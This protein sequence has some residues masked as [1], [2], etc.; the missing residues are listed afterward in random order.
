MSNVYKIIW[1]VFLLST[2][3]FAQLKARVNPA[4]T[5]G[6]SVSLGGCNSTTPGVQYNFYRG[7]TAKGESTTPLNATPLSTCSYVDTT[8]VV[9]GTY[10]YVAKAY[11]SVGGLSAGSNEVSAAIPATTGANTPTGL[12]VAAPATL[13]WT[14]PATQSGYNLLA[15]EIYRGT[16][17]TTIGTTPVAIVLGSQI[18]YADTSCTAPC[19]YYVVAYDLLNDM[20]FTP[21]GPS[22]IASTASTTTP[23]AHV[24][25]ACSSMTVEMSATGAWPA[26]CT[27]SKTGDAISAFVYCHPSA[28]TI[29]GITL[30]APGY[31]VNGTGPGSIYQADAPGNT[32]SNQVG[33]TFGIIALNTS[34]VTFTASFA[35]ASN[36]SDY[37]VSL[38][39]EYTN[40]SQVGGKT[41]FNASGS[42]AGASGT[43]NQAGAA[44]TPPLA[45][46]AVSV[47]C[48]S[49]GGATAATSPWILGE[50]DAAT[51]WD[52][53][54]YQ[55]VPTAGK[56]VTPAFTDSTG[57]YVV[58]SVA[59]APAN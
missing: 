36:C 14:A 25:G 59:I 22:N 48:I 28:G 4:A 32:G 39:E 26:S 33:A 17:P 23:V 55:I 16:S 43:C 10:F 5:G 42:A 20:S 47:A 2:V 29:T 58:Q 13:Q 30:T 54:E 57:A 56:T 44:V 8:V 46:E 9:G 53:D 49:T 34:P 6:P 21:S 18:T 38:S 27:P 11:L 19:S 45:N 41:T 15:Y 52:G 31:T 37:G 12:T 1:V 40:N 3:S 7:T 35:G 51:N 24:A 50:V